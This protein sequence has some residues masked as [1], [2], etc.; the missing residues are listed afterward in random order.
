MFSKLLNLQRKISS[1]NSMMMMKEGE[2]E[3][4]LRGKFEMQLKF[5]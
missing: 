2:R 4:L 5:E 3:M 1:E